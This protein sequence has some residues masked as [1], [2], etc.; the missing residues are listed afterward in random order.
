MT[1]V[2]RRDICIVRGDS[3]EEN[4]GFGANFTDLVDDPSLYAVNMVFR[5]AQDDSL[6]PY[7]SLTATP[8]ATVGE[9]SFP[10]LATITATGAQTSSLPDW[11]HV[12]YV[13]L[14]KIGGD[15]T[16]IYQG[17]IKIDD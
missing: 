17:K 14:K 8:E 7:L 6:T 3:F 12:Y 16:R 10:V 4:V 2:T 15:P 5:E 9:D 1:C 11:N 13:E